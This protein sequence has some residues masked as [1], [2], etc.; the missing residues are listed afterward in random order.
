VFPEHIRKKIGL[1][2]KGKIISKATRLKMSQAKLGKP[3]CAANFGE[4]TNKGSQ[5]PKAWTYLIRFPDGSEH[6]I[7]G[8]R[9]FCR[10]KGIQHPK[11]SAK[12]R[13][14]GY[15][16]LRRFNDHPEME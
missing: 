16:I 6:M 14:K 3:E 8:I 9:N 1:A 7:T 10:E 4:H 12:G 2:Q 13:T 11:L 5:N 15:S